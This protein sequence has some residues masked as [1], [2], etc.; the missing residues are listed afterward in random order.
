MENENG[1]EI[2]QVIKDSRKI[3]MKFGS[4]SLAKSDGTPNAEFMENLARQ[5]KTLMD[6]GKQ[7]VLVSSGAQI[8]GIATI[9]E[10]ARKKDV[11]YRQALCAVGQVELMNQWR[12]AFDKYGIHI[13]QLL[14][15]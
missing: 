1:K 5:C 10:W 2:A 13:G 4:N 12:L 7:V 9:K 15:T 11:H 8:S 3:V 6:A 14:L